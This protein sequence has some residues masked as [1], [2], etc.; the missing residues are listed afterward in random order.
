MKDLRFLVDLEVRASVILEAGV[1][2][3]LKKVNRQTRALYE[4]YGRPVEVIIENKEVK[5]IEFIYSS[6]TDRIA[7]YVTKRELDCLKREL[8]I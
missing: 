8:S 2:I 7:G 1:F 3:K 4:L 5:S 6:D